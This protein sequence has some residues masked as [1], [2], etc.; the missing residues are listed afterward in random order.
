[1]SKRE[2]MRLGLEK[3]TTK[4]Y[5][6]YKVL[7][8]TGELRGFRTD[9]ELAHDILGYLHSQGVVIKVDR[10]LPSSGDKLIGCEF[11]YHLREDKQAQLDRAGYVVVEPL[12]KE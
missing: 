1:M 10:E 6:R 7:L 5:D 12:V 9:Y 11:C 3:I 8:E 2:E 4:A